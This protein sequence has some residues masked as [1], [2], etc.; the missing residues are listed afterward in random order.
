VVPSYQYL[1]ILKEKVMDKKIVGK[2]KE[3]KTKK[4]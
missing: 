1:V 3:L 2:I 4:G